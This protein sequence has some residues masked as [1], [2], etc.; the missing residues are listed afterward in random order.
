VITDVATFVGGYPFRHLNDP[1]AA[2]L[3][4]QLDRLAI[5]R[6]W[7]GHLPSVWHR[8]PGPAF[9][10]LDA[11]L[12]PHR[13][14]LLPVPTVH[15][16]LP[17]WE[18]ELNEAVALGC[19][20]IRVFPMQQ[21]LDPAGGEMRVLTAGAAAL[22]LPVVLTVRFEDLRQRHPL[23]GA[24]DLPPAAVRALARSDPQARI[25]VTHADRGFI[26]EVHFG[27][28]PA[29]AE[30]LLW[31][32]SWVWG[33]PEDHLALLLRTVGPERFTLGTGMPLRLPDAP[34]AKLDLLD[35][36]DAHRAGI[37]GQNLERWRLTW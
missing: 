31:D 19:P 9:R 23:D 1:S 24:P 26:E 33:P 17:D 27:L 11:A 8:D 34:F 36:P 14:R 28:A 16:G 30:R 4:R 3:V 29:E 10:E 5:E 21:G 35:G 15:P 25:L 20:A 2:A 18:R 6:A 22:R 13:G 12:S 32:I 7:V 37:L